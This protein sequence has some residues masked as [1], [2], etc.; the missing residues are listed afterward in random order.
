MER[1]LDSLLSQIPNWIY[2]V[3]MLVVAFVA[4]TIVKALATKLLKA[5][6]AEEKLAKLG[7]KDAATG[8]SIEF[9]AKLAYFV[10]FLL[11]LPGVLDKLGMNSVS[12]PIT[13]M[14]NSFLAFIPKV[15]GA[16][17]IIAVGIFIAKIVR[18]LLVALLR[19]TKIDQLQAKAGIL[20]TETSALSTII[21]NVIYGVILLVMITSALDAL[22]I[23]AISRPAN[24]IVN[25]IFD[26]IP[27][28][29]GAI[30][31]IAVGVFI[32]NLVAKL[33]GSLLAGVGTDK[34]IEKMTGTPAK[35]V[36]LSKLISS[37]V[38]YVLIIIFIVQGI[39]VLHLPVLT[40]IGAAV[41]GYMPAVLSAVII[42]AI[43]LFAANT[44]ETALVKKFPEAKVSALVA[45]IAI[46]VLTAFLCLSQLNVANVIVETTFILIIAALCIAFAVAFG[47]GGRKFAETTLDKLEKKMDDKK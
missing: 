19:A 36:V 38:K 29:L 17:I 1:F 2:A 20:V 41:I 5:L 8:S 34:L 16:G 46:Y 13:N 40:D 15:V 11:F 28:V 37:I 21:S 30:V 32:S 7:V 4:A 9:I 14:V 42:V 39:N 25:S 22:G 31:I 26:M 10:T 12:Q 45:K 33:L 35:K 3:L 27:Y 18:D 23:E 24:N 43:G 6:K 44:A 47:V